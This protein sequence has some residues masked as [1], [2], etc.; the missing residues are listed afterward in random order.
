MESHQPSPDRH[1]DY[2]LVLFDG[3]CNFCNFWV[4]FIYKRDKKAAFRF[5]SLQ[6]EA[7]RPFLLRFQLSDETFD[8]VVLIEQD[9]IYTESSAALRICRKLDGAWKLMYG[10]ILVPKPVRDVIYRFVARNR[11]RWFGRRESCMLPTKQMR[12]RFLPE[13]LGGT[14]DSNLKR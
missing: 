1:S 10:F 8:S 13:E 11:Y 3:V 12:E 4:K 7:A 9:K 6:S 14:S 2:S 5:A